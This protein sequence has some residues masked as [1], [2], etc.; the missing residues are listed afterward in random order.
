MVTHYTFA[1]CVI[2][3]FCIGYMCGDSFGDRKGE[4]K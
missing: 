4:R 1:F 3:A 2:M